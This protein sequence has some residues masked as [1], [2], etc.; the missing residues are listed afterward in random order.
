[1]GNF[2]GAGVNGRWAVGDAAPYGE[3]TG[4]AVSGPM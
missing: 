2:E 3:V 4:S 1:M